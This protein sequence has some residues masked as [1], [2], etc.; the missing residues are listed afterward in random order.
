MGS[1]LNKQGGPACQK[2]L[3]KWKESKWTVELKWDEIVT[4]RPSK[5]RKLDNLVMPSSS[6]RCAELEKKVQLLG[7]KLKDVT[8]KIEML[9]NLTSN[10]H[11]HCWPVIKQPKQQ[12]RGMNIHLNMKGKNSNSLPVMLIQ[13]YHLQKMTNSHQ[14]KFIF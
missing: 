11:K 13:H 6:K 4:P 12:S 14:Q 1:M 5:K 2:T 3:D 9:K 8:N 7:S 10:C